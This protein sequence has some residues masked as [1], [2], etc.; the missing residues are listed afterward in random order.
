[1]PGCRRTPRRRLQSSFASYRFPNQC[2]TLSPDC[3]RSRIVVH[4]SMTPPR[5]R[6]DA[7]DVGAECEAYIWLRFF[8]FFVTFMPACCPAG[9]PGAD[10]CFGAALAAPLPL[11]PAPPPPAPPLPPPCA[12]A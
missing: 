7:I 12:T 4:E 2:P 5:G 10:S 11:P 3:G 9:P 8:F 1:M 6:G